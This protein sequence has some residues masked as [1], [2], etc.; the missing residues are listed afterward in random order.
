MS[1]PPDLILGQ[2]ETEASECTDTESRGST[3]NLTGRRWSHKLPSPA[4]DV[5]FTNSLTLD[6]FRLHGLGSTDERLL[7]ASAQALV[8]PGHQPLLAS[9]GNL[10]RHLLDV[11]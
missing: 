11:F 8:L 9:S 7:P 1:E 6:G 3:P 5:T 10:H 2:Q 4:T